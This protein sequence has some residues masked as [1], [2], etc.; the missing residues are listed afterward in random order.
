[1]EFKCPDPDCP[2]DGKGSFSIEIKTESLM[3]PNN[4]ATMFCPH[5]NSRLVE[6]KVMPATAAE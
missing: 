3:D 2:F 6:K 4:Y 5:C 1:M